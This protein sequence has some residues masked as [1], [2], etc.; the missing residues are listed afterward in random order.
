VNSQ[1][2]LIVYAKNTQWCALSLG[3]TV[4]RADAVHGYARAEPAHTIDFQQ[5]DIFDAAASLRSVRL[6]VM[7]LIH[8]NHLGEAKLLGQHSRPALQHIVRQQQ[9]VA[10]LADGALGESANPAHRT[11]LGGDGMH[12]LERTKARVH[13]YQQRRAHQ[14]GSYGQS[15]L[16][17][18]FTLGCRILHTRAKRQLQAV[19]QASQIH[20]KR[21]MAVYPRV[22]APDQ[23]FLGAPVVHSKGVQF[24]RGVATFQRTEVNRLAIDTAA[25]QQLVHL[26]CQFKLRCSMG[27]HALAQG[28]TRWNN[29]QAQCALEEGALAQALDSIK[30]AFSHVQQGKIGSK[31]SLLATLERTGNLGSIR[32]LTLT[33]L[34]YFR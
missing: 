5:R 8:R 14:I 19:A 22:S 30:V 32:A 18:V 28:W 34:R 6:P 7:A 15:P 20:R 24:H 12:Q 27:I 10:M 31:I 23:L 25:K 4:Y 33:H 3:I 26:R 11:G 16:Q 17:V 2:K 1:P 9:D 13:A 21:A 29:A